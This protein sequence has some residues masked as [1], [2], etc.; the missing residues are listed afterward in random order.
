MAFSDFDPKIPEFEKFPE[1]KK[2]IP[3][4]IIISEGQCLVSNI[5]YF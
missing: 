1:S 5:I 2:T 3:T 4:K